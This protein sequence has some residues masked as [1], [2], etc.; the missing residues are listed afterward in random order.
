MLVIEGDG[1]KRAGLETRHAGGALF[2][3]DPWNTQ[4]RISGNSIEFA[5]FRTWG[6][7]ALP[8]D[9]GGE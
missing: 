5:R 7:L 6:L 2:G 4:L 9:G 8:A 1:A 3:I